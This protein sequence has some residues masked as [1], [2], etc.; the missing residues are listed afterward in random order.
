MKKIVYIVIVICFVFG[1]FTLARAQETKV[2]DLANWEHR[3]AIASAIGLKKGWQGMIKVPKEFRDQAIIHCLNLSAMLGHDHIKI[4]LAMG[5][6]GT[7]CLSNVEELNQDDNEGWKDICKLFRLEF[8]SK[9]YP[10]KVLCGKA[11]KVI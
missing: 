7:L 6:M 8:I 11:M 3:L 2:I 9:P 10:D 5:P 1:F 4:P